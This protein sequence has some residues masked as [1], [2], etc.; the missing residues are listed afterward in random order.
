MTS[1]TRGALVY[2]DDQRLGEVN[3]TF[4]RIRTGKREVRI[5]KS[6]FRS[7]TVLVAVKPNK[8]AR[9][10]VDLERTPSPVGKSASGATKAL[11]A[12][13]HYN[14][15]VTHFKKGRLEQA[16]LS[17]EQ[18]LKLKPSMADAFFMRAE[19]SSAE[20]Y[21][22]DAF[23]DYLRA[24]E[25]W[26]VQKRFGD[27]LASLDNAVEQSPDNPIGYK[28]RG[29]IYDARGHSIIAVED[30]NK[31]LKIDK[32]YYEARLALGISLFNNGS[33]R[34]ALKELRRARDYN[35]EDPV[36]Y[37]YLMLASLAR[38]DYGDVNNYFKQFKTIA[39]EA[40]LK[41]FYG[42]ARFAGVRKVFKD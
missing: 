17:L 38:K 14:R 15:G 36:L 25:I 10:D 22:D 29:D 12:A 21:S 41:R 35:D 5:E 39:S 3:N 16:L 1:K 13:D 34:R 42:D 4:R 8:L 2:L 7:T 33:T 20:G 40:D 24:G 26:R 31:A 32:K 6:G 23:D 30:Y 18:A 28:V 11:S 27:A 37:H 19:I 9:V